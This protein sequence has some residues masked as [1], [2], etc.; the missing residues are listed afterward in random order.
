MSSLS[1]HET[2][3]IHMIFLSSPLQLVAGS[4]MIRH[5]PNDSRRSEPDLEAYRLATP[6]PKDISLENHK[7]TIGKP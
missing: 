1:H 2:W 7:K 4:A 5:D 3:G 6:G